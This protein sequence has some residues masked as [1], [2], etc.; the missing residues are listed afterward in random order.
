MSIYG[1]RGASAEQPENTL[2]AFRRAIELEIAGVELDVHLSADGVPVVIHDDTLDRTTDGS[3][4]VSG[5][6]VEQLRA[7]DAGNGEYVPTLAEVLA[8]FGPEQ[9]V[10]IEIKSNAAGQA[11]IDV[12]D[13]MPDLRWA[14]SSF[15]WSVL[16]YV[17]AQR[18][19][20]DL[21]PL[22]YGPRESMDE[23]ITR[24]SMMA[25]TL[26]AAAAWADSLRTTPNVLDAALE[27]AAALN[28]T[29]LSI[30]QYGLTEDAVRMIHDRGFRAW[31]WTVNEPERALELAA[32][33]VDAFC[34]DDPATLKA[35]DLSGSC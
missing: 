30:G 1:H 15:D 4:P 10:N 32:I 7:L 9:H 22:T 11:V 5:H 27:L 12:V 16:R 35:L 23:V 34:T 25:D 19:G 29:T 17:K 8:L 28:S 2:A 3:G 18:P 31:C 6:T 20:A 33:G 13:G 14:I 26:P 21:W 24:V